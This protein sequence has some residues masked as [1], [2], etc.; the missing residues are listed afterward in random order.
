MRSIALSTAWGIPA[1]LGAGVALAD[2]VAFNNFG[3]GA[4]YNTENGYTI[5]GPLAPVPAGRVSADR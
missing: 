2:V 3:P 4:S 5:Y 1:F